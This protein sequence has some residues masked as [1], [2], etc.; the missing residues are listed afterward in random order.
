MVEQKALFPGNCNLPI[1][2][3]SVFTWILYL[4]RRG[5]FQFYGISVACYVELSKII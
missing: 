4:D 3:F 1:Y 5:I 2:L